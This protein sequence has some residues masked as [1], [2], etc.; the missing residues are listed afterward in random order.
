LI[1]WFGGAI[2]PAAKLGEYGT[3]LGNVANAWLCM[4]V[5]RIAPSEEWSPSSSVKD[6]GAVRVGQDRAR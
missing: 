6:A 3:F 4:M 2:L 5:K 1:P